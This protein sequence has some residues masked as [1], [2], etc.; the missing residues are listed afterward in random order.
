MLNQLMFL[1]FLVYTIQISQVLNLFYPTSFD[2]QILP[3]ELISEWVYCG[4]LT[5]ESV[6]ILNGRKLAGC[7]MVW[8]SD[9]F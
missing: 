7:G 6:Q 4:D 2:K 8:F 9:P 1:V 5:S 3:S